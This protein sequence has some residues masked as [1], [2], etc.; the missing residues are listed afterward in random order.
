MRSDGEASLYLDT[1]L[2]VSLILPEARSER[3]GEWLGSRAE[4]RCISAW[5]KA[6]VAGVLAAKVRERTLTRLAASEAQRRFQVS[7][8]PFL[9]EIDID[10]VA[11]TRCIALLDDP[12]LGLRAPDALHLAVCQADPSRALATADK[13]LHRAARAV[14]APAHLLR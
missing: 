2:L 7:V 6:E 5:T 1:N 3:V 12:T 13:K 14:G 8:L 9:H 11:W 10:R 4:I